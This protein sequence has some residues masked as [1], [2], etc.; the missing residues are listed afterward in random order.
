MPKDLLQHVHVGGP[1]TWH[2]HLHTVLYICSTVGDRSDGQD[3]PRRLAA[4]SRSRGC[5]APN[6]MPACQGD[7]QG[8][9]QEFSQ[10]GSTTHTTSNQ[11]YAYIKPTHNRLGWCVTATAL[12]FP[13]MPGGRRRSC[14]SAIR[15]RG[16][17]RLAFR[18]PRLAGSIQGGGSAVNQRL[19]AL[20]LLASENHGRRAEGQ[21]K[22]GAGFTCSL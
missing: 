4:T 2:T 17:R 11:V 3:P 1:P 8:A 18:S 12:S 7:R 9:R 10:P 19:D 13:S 14:I 16:L 6:D 15:R 20:L 5:E 21:M 22:G